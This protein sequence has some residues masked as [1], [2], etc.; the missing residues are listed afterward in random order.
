MARSYKAVSY[1]NNVDESLFGNPARKSRASIPSNSVV[2]SAGE[3]NAMR[4][5]SILRSPADEMRERAMREAALEEKQKI[6]RMRK[7]KMLQMEID[8]KN[9]AKKSDIELSNME[10][11]KAIRELA[12]N[13]IDENLDMVKM[14][15]SLGA[16]AAAFTIRDQQLAEREARSHQEGDYD[17][18]M[19]LMMEIDRL[20]EL[21]ERER[22]EDEK[23]NKR[24]QDREVIVSQI[25][26]NEKQKLLEE[27]S[28]ER[29]NQQM[30]ALMRKYEQE[31]KAAAEKRSVEVARSKAEIVQANSESIRRKEM[32]KMKELEEMESLRIYQMKKDAE[33]AARERHEEELASEKREQQRKLLAQQEKSQNK[34]AEIDELRARRY[35]EERER[36]ARNDEKNKAER[37]RQQMIEL[38]NAR[39]AQADGK[40]SIMAREALMQQEEYEDAIRFGMKVQQREAAEADAK[41]RAADMHRTKLQAQ[42]DSAAAE[43]KLNSTS[44]FEEGQKLKEEFSAER[45]KLGAIRDKMV[46]DLLKKGVNPKYLSEMK[47]CDIQKLQ[48]R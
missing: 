8:A 28:R 26:L 12:E 29:E 9:K 37:R 44:K 17:K 47:M 13:Q 5:R 20:K 2:V 24:I 32:T 15:N 31:D 42:I 18:R 35:A 46:D 14:L 30:L 10:R 25:A 4:Q 48:M 34:Q 16:R 39:K 33:L 19:D 22:I 21:S 45:A 7:E 38:S 11:E 23:R 40:K 27:E 36:K 43:R 41:Q 3:I 6:S 1:G